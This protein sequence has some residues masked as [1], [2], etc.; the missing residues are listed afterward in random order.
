MSDLSPFSDAQAYRVKDLEEIRG[1]RMAAA[2]APPADE[3]Q[4][5]RQAVGLVDR[6]DRGLLIIRGNDRRAWLNNLVTNAVTLL[7]EDTG[8]YAFATNVQ[9]R[10]LFDLNIL[11]VAEALWLD[12]DRLAVAV[13]ASH[14]DRHLISEDVRI[15][16]A[17]GHV[18]R[19]G[20]CG[21]QAK[22]LANSIGVPNF[23]ALAPLASVPLD[24][25][26]RLFR[27]DFAGLPG[28]E[29]V[30]PR[31]RAAA[32]WDR[33]AQA[34][35][36]P[37]G[38]RTL[39]VLRLEAGIPWLGRDMDGTVLPPETGQRERAINDRKGCYLGQEI[40][41]RMR[42][43]GAL[44]RRLVQLRVADGDGLSVPAPLRRDAQT[45]GRV[46]SLARHPTQPYWVGLGYLS[47]SVTGFA[48]ITVGEP[49]RAVT[50]CSS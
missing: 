38:Y 13:A 48:E 15:E 9:G 14:F 22:E 46:T 21:P 43:R 12:V 23:P 40:I 2:F 32:W 17:G 39:E 41:E 27:H 24:D 7:A 33:L 26:T 47:T 25:D 30:L 49:P 20:C 18:A 4:A 5:A 42:S 44:A 28:F 50:I 11:C 35:A 10:I 3:Y 34:G 8:Q 36:R 19:L 37:I 1:V 45:L 6:S 29:L 31:G 16:D